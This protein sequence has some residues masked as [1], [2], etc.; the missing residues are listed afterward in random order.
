MSPQ[1]VNR[2]LSW[3]FN[4]NAPIRMAKANGQQSEVV[5]RR[6][7]PA[8]PRNVV[9]F[10]MSDCNQSAYNRRQLVKPPLEMDP[11]SVQSTIPSSM[12]NSSTNLPQEMITVESKELLHEIIKS[13]PEITAVKENEIGTLKAALFRAQ[14]R[15]NVLERAYNQH[16]VDGNALA[17]AIRTLNEQMSEQNRAANVQINI[18]NL[19]LRSRDK[20]LKEQRDFIQQLNIEKENW[21]KD[22]HQLVENAKFMQIHW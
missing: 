6:H 19:R 3:Q 15:V 2:I 18:L 12:E 20:S 8:S 22:Y 13:S 11:D 16:N 14:T 4:C 7:P 17:Q 21:K 1:L 10:W 9:P 5:N